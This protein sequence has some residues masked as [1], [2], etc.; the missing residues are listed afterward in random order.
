MDQPIVQPEQPE[1]VVAAF[2]EEFFEEATARGV[3]PER[4][5]AALRAHFADASQQGEA[6]VEDWGVWDEERRLD[7]CCL[8]AERR[9]AQELPYVAG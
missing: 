4:W 2:D 5:A 7:W 8:V 3:S 6:L 1:P 9:A